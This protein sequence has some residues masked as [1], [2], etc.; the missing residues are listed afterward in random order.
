MTAALV[1]LTAVQIDQILALVRHNLEN[2]LETTVTIDADVREVRLDVILASGGDPGHRQYASVG[3]TYTISTASKEQ[4]ARR[5]DVD[6]PRVVPR[7]R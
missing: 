4:I 2:S 7:M 6:G 1:G 5:A 3:T